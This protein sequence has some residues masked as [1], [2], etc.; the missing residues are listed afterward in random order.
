M[1]IILATAMSIVSMVDDFNIPQDKKDQLKKRHCL[2]TR[3]RT[4][5]F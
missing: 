1:A 3:K 4:A 5:Y 2:N